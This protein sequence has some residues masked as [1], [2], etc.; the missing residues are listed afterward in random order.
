MN[1][2]PND[3][4]AGFARAAVDLRARMVDY[5]NSALAHRYLHALFADMPDEYGAMTPDV[6]TTMHQITGTPWKVGEPYIVA[7]AMTAIIAA[8]AQA[9]DLTGEV[10]PDDIAPCDHGV[11]LF[12]E[13]LYHRGLTGKVSS[14]GA[15]TW[16]RIATN[17]EAT[18]VIIGWADQHDPHDPAAARRRADLAHEPDLARQFGPYILSH[19]T[20]VPVGRPVEPAD[21]PQVDAADR[22]WEPAPDGRFCIDETTTLTRACTTIAYA[23][24]R[25]QAQPLATVAA[26]PM[27]RPA[28]KR[29]AR[30]G[31]RHDTRVIM[32]RR[33]S[34]HAEPA[35]GD[36]KWHYR[37][38]FV[39]RGHW[40][41]LTDTNG[42]TYRIWI[43]AHIK[44]PDGAPLLHGEKVAVLAR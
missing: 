27:D 10:L 26:A 23:F 14:L 22:D 35:D 24:W 21:P 39:V 40:R 6:L 8:A 33:T 32:L 5:H 34:A 43:N 29:A 3:T 2:L 12:P 18:W 16:T 13:P 20:M 25:I 38:R 7:P 4:L 36:P 41:R 28:R 1:F 30:A 15:I 31:I 44:G 19:Y 17:G 11:L 42:H 9:L 37:V